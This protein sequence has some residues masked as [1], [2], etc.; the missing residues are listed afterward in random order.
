MR[1]SLLTDPRAH[2]LRPLNLSTVCLQSG[3]EDLRGRVLHADALA[4]I[5][6][7]RPAINDP[8][9]SDGGDILSQTSLGSRAVCQR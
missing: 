5:G 9:N 8:W 2:G 7:G 3:L 4:R 1:D 6:H